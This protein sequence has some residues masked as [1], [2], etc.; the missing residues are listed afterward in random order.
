MEFIEMMAAINSPH[1]K[2]KESKKQVHVENHIPKAFSQ[3][4]TN[5]K[6][7]KPSSKKGLGIFQEISNVRS[8]LSRQCVHGLPSKILC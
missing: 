6:S 2:W 4:H 3:F 8:I 7:K 5:N 1:N